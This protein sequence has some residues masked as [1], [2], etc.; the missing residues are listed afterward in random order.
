MKNIDLLL[1]FGLPHNEMAIDLL[2]ELKT[3]TL[4]TLV[5]HATA[6]PRRTFADFARALPHEGWLATQLGL[7][8]DPAVDGNLPVAIAAMRSFGLQADAGFWFMLQPVH[9]HVT[10]DHL[11]LTD[12]RQLALSEEESRVLFDVAKKV[13]EEAGKKILYGD[14][15]TWF[16]RAD[17]WAELTT[18]TPDAA[19]GHNADIWMP[20]GTGERMWRKLQNEVQ[21][22][23]H[24]HSINEKREAAGIN[25]VNSVWLWG[26]APATMQSAPLA[27]TH[28][29]KPSLSLS[30]LDRLIPQQI[31]ANSAADLIATNSAAALMI[32]D[33]LV[34]H[35]FSQ[36]WLEWLNR[37]HALDQNW[38]A[39][40]LEGL[41]SGKVTQIRLILTHTTG[42]SEF[43][44]SRNSLRKFWVKPSLAR[45]AP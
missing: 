45:L 25:P 21:M 29:V 44:V 7:T 22:E 31:E 34:E 19:C 8:R 17:D 16:V 10:R 32:F 27:Y 30:A 11:V 9:I 4:A 33:Q 41:K 38:L 36:D 3:P 40:L 35:A 13:F 39:P 5:A 20:K 1:P 18:A 12:L 28:L 23:W 37:M 24:F 43:I 14:A 15:R 2:R 6:R 42:L 26:G